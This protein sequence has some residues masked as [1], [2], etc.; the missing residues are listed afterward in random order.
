MDVLYRD[1][2]LLVVNK[3]SGLLTHRGLA[4]DRDNALVRARALAGCYVH[5]V[6]RLDRATSGVLVFALDPD[7]ARA[8]GKQLQDGGFDKHY[9]ALVRGTPPDTL[10]IDYALPPI[11]AGPGAERKPARTSL[12]RL[13]SFERFSLLECV[14]HTGRA[15]QLRR[16]L[17]HI[18][19][20]V[21]GDTRY[22]DGTHNRALRERFGLH[23][24]ALHAARLAFTHPCSDDRLV[25]SAP[26]PD[27]LAA[28]LRAMSL[29]EAAQQL[30][31]R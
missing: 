7:A 30:T 9:L 4:N 12:R 31:S 25:L 21:S 20:P 8:L 17:K 28:A 18:S 14:P 1:D 13:G 3:P 27:D 6:H 2:V 19:H 26:L 15:H 10:E 23:R 5:P 11:E 29:L 16:H 24:L 22:G